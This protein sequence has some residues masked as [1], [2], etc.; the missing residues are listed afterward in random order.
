MNKIIYKERP[1]IMGILNVTPDSFFDGNKYNQ[2]KSAILHVEKMI[3]EGVDIIDIGGESTKPYSQSVSLAEEIKRVIPILKEIR[4][5]FPKIIISVDTTKSKLM[6][7]A[8]D[9]GA[10]LINDVSGLTWDKNSIDVIK[11]N[12]IPIV[13][14]HSPWKPKEMQ[15]KYFYKNGVLDDIYLFF[16]ER[17]KTLTNKGIKTENIILDP[18]IGFGKSVDDNF[19]IISNLSKF[20]DLKQ[21]ILLG[22]SNKSYITKTL[23][24]KERKEGNIIT[25]YIACQNNISILRVHDVASTKRTIT[26]FNKFNN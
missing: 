14:M 1:L 10:D 22:A 12:N 24:K 15:D 19:L 5:K 18:G 8:I 6:Q 20:N 7:Q 3:N 25:E 13:I 23:N 21:P 2:E 11:N 9:N 16:K 4:K 26:L 17:I